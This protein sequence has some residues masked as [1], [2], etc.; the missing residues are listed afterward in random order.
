[1]TDAV[2]VQ[3]FPGHMAKTRRLITE[4]LP[5]IDGV[6]EIADARIPV[7]S[8]NPE[9]NAWLGDKPRLLLLNKADIADEAVVLSDDGKLRGC[10]YQSR[11]RKAHGGYP[12]ILIGIDPFHRRSQDIKRSLEHEKAQTLR[13]CKHDQRNERK[14]ASCMSLH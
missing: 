8:R 13:E 7:S 3:W 6:V 10:D 12:V 2:S 1:M 14:P 4:S 11:Q 9:L 5:L